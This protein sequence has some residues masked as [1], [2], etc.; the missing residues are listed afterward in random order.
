M[1]LKRGSR[2]LIGFSSE[3]AKQDHRRAF[4][5]AIPIMGRYKTLGPGAWRLLTPFNARNGAFVPVS[6]TRLICF[7]IARPPRAYSAAMML[8]YEAGS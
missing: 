8:L 2:I 3:R 6:L 5:H 1:L 7:A 4:D